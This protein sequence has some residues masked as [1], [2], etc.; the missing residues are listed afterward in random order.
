MF[1]KE[2]ARQPD[3]SKHFSRQFSSIDKVSLIRILADAMEQVLLDE[4]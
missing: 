2:N 4:R 3:V 1:I